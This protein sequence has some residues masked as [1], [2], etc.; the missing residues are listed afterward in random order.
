M[1]K[2]KCLKISGK[3]IDEHRKIMSDFL[4]RK[5]KRNEVVHHINGDKKDNRIENLVVLSIS[6]HSRLHNKGKTLSQETKNKIKV[7]HTGRPHKKKLSIE[8]IIFVRE[9]YIA[10]HPVYGA[11]ALGRKFGVSKDTIRFYTKMALGAGFKPA[12]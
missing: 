11:R 3:R 1:Y 8:D 5:L 4:G 2:Y 12:T 9:H 6:E 7:A 10:K